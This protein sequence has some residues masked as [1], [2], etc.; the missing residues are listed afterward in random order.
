MNLNDRV[1]YPHTLHFP[2]SPGL[3]NDDKIIEDIQMEGH[4][5][6]ITEKIT[7]NKCTYYHK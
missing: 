3:Q 5:V 6:T 1:K 4:D 7:T 2:W